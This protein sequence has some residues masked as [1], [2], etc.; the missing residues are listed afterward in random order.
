MR[1]FKGLFFIFVLS[2]LFTSCEEKKA[3]SS[4]SIPTLT[5][6]IDGEGAGEQINLD[7]VHIDNTKEGVAFKPFEKKGESNVASFPMTDWDFGT[8]GVRFGT[9]SVIL[10]LDKFDENI[11]IKG[12]IEDFKTYTFEVTGSK[13]SV[14]FKQFVTDL[15]TLKDRNALMGKVKAFVANENTALISKVTVA[16]QFFRNPSFKQELLALKSDLNTS[17]SDSKVTEQ[18]SNLVQ[19]IISTIAVGEKAPEIDIPGPDGKNIPL[20][21]LRGKIVLLDFWASW[22]RPCRKNNPHIV[23]LYKKY[24]NKG[25]DI[26][27]VSLDKSKGSWMSAIEKDGLIWPSHVSE[28]KQWSS[29]AAAAYKVSGIPATFLI[30]REGNLATLN[31]RNPY[32]LEQELLKLL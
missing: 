28:L 2:V 27:S 1:I 22:C 4:T 6:I 7:R 18:F 29:K 21:S 26:Y 13:S 19:Q 10:P 5:V 12:S 14:D 23:S 17:Q 9:T 25:F 8:Y 3:T 16:N 24:K 15:Q 20:S 32:Q 31:V 11:T 30:D